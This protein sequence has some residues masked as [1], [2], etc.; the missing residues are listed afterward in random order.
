MHVGRKG[1]WNAV[2]SPF[3]FKAEIALKNK[4]YF[5]KG[6]SRYIME[7]GDISSIHN[8]SGSYL[9]MKCEKIVR[10]I[11]VLDPTASNISFLI[12]K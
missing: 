11:T 6:V 7:S 12:R 1:V 8:I 2:P 5:Q 10:L 3:C 4:V 9:V